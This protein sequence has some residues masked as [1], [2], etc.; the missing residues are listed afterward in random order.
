MKVV[1]KRTHQMLGIM[2][3]RATKEGGLDLTEV[4][5]HW[6]YDLMVSEFPATKEDSQ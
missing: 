6:A 4:I 2:R 1:D 3:T 5:R